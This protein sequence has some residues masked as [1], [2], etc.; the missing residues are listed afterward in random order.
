MITKDL[1]S[2]REQKLVD[3]CFALVFTATDKR[4][5][6]TFAK[7]TQEQKAQWVAKELR[8]CGID[9]SPCGGLWGLIEG[10]KR[11]IYR[12]GPRGE[13]SSVVL[14]KVGKVTFYRCDLCKQEITLGKQLSLI[15]HQNEGSSTARKWEVCPE[16]AP[17]LIET[18]GK[19]TLSSPRVIT[20]GGGK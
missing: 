12:A 18:L 13:C 14:R 20:H 4:W 17:K 11:G 16:C 2:S 3:I 10:V 15:L 8:E 7:W 5:R 1:P 6:S 19:G 9:T